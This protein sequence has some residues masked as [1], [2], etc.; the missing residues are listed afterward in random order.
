[1]RFRNSVQAA[2]SALAT[3]TAAVG[4]TA[5]A[6][7]TTHAATTPAHAA[8]TAPH[9]ATTLP[10]HLFAPYFEAYS[11]DSPAALAQQSGAKYLT[12]A[13]VQAPSKGSCTVDWNGS[14][15]QPIS[16][17]VYG[18]DIA[19]IR[20]NGGDVI[21]SFGGY[22]ADHG[23]TEIAD[24]CTNVASIAAAYESL[25]TTYGVTRIDLDTEDRSLTNTAGIDRRNKAIK[26]V[27]DWAAASG[28]T[29]Q[30][31]Y[32]LPASTSG[33]EST[34]VDILRNAVSNGARVDVVNIMTFDYYDGAS[35]EMATD[36]E[37]AATGLEAQ[38]AALYP[39]KSAAQL[40]SMISVTE[41]VGIDDYGT[42]ETF[43]TADATTVLDWATA[44]GLAG[45]SFWA[46][47]RD[48]GGC[49]GTKGSDT[50][51]GIS[52]S[53][54]FFSRAFEPFTGGGG[55]PANDFS[56][57]VSPSSGS[58][59]PGS[60][61][62]AAVS[63]AVTAGSAQPVSLTVSGAPSGVTATLS[64]A[65]VSAGGS[66]TLTV[67][68]STA[69]TPGVYTLTITGSAASGSHGASYTLTVAGSGGG[70]S[71]VN[72]GFETGTT[73]PWT[74][75]AGD[76]VVTSPVHSG[77]GAL[78]VSPASGQTGECDQSVVLRPNTTYS[79]KAW[80]QG[81][82]AHIGVKGG[83]TAGVSASSASWRQLSVSFTT[84]STGSVTVYTRG[85]TSGGSFYADDFTIQ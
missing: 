25:V 14:A 68:A 63:T 47:E 46:L 37:T 42:A 29:V 36:S 83:A 50:C 75:Q 72:P 38:L 13:F 4:L 58:V 51:S 43:T 17:S 7:T 39:G 24:S 57:S 5:A 15:S 11:G 84:D 65:S 49:V 18:A 55:V 80:I 69:A 1:M 22:S 67:S 34:G 60:S 52:Q 77:N 81:S 35:H 16:S 6:T 66:S 40:W 85:A 71:I 33:L 76:A 31:A 44:K 78:R 79:L 12:M 23:G 48:N 45:L 32:T 59:A 73:S 27:E 8:T 70:S 26:A 61:A 74:C 41:M 54:W 10:A 21:P 28:R 9:A 2:L 62:T 56:V 82:H 20:A 3:A 30:F 64:P 19:T 53:T